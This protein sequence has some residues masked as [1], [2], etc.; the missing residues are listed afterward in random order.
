MPLALA[1]DERH[2]HVMRIDKGL[3]PGDHSVRHGDAVDDV[4]AAVEIILGLVGGNRD[5]ERRH[6]MLVVLLVFA[7]QHVHPG[8]I[9]RQIGEIGL[10]FRAVQLERQGGGVVLRPAFIAGQQAPFVDLR[11]ARHHRDRAPGMVLPGIIDLAPLQDDADRH[12][13]HL[14]HAPIIAG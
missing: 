3:N 7:Q 5:Q 11:R 9:V 1:L 4:L 2:V 10:G 14:L 6:F 8:R 12:G 13:F